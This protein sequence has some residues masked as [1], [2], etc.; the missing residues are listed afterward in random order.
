MEDAST[1]HPPASRGSSP[2]CITP[3]HRYG[4][5]WRLSTV[6]RDVAVCHAL[7]CGRFDC[8]LRGEGEGRQRGV[9]V[10]FLQKGELEVRQWG[11]STPLSAGDI[12]V[13][14]GWLPV[15]LHSPDRLQALIFDLPAWWAIDRFLDR[16]A[17][18]PDLRISRSYFASGVITALAEAVLAEEGA[19]D[20]EAQ[21]T[22]MLAGLLKTALSARAEDHA[23][24]PR[25]AGRI[26]RIMQFIVRNIDRPGLSARNAAAG[27]KCSPRTIY[28]TCADEGTTFNAVMMELR[29]LNAQHRLLRSEGQVAQI[30]YAVGFASLSHFSR[31]FKARFGVPP[32]A[33]R[34]TRSRL[35]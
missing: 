5:D 25:V 27:L 10:V 3:A 22:E 18:T 21:G 29:L 14:C 34:R 23:P 13:C 35:H 7:S 12:F 30:A 19:G 20:A 11:R 8:A 26:G 4:P 17:V 32:T 31:L 6:K 2:H 15:S 28:Q 16:F 1:L 9:Q 33:F 24:M